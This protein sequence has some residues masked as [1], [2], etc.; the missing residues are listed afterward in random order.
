MFMILWQRLTSETGSSNK[1]RKTMKKPIIFAALVFCGNIA[2]AQI[3]PSNEQ[4]STII[5]QV[6]PNINKTAY[7]TNLNGKLMQA[8]P[9]PA[10]DMVTIQHISSPER[11]VISIISVDGKIL[12]QRVV[13]PNSL[14]TKLNVAMLHKGTYILRYDNS[15]GD[16]R[17]LQLIKN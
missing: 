16:I 7:L 6:S 12:Q 5:T 3:I 13:V 14:E 9:N 4:V 2:F 15:K 11:G 10:I 1:R 8:Y 17:T